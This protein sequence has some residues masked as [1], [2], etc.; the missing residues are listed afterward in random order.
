MI[1][2]R[3][4]AKLRAQDWTA[5]TIELVIVTLGVL[6]ALGLQQLV[7]TLSERTA[8]TRARG[9]IREELGL[10]L[11]LLQQRQQIQP[12][13]D[14]RLDEIGA[15]LDRLSQGEVENPP[16]WIG[17]PQ[18]WNMREYRWN[19]ASQSGHASLLSPEEQDTF[20]RI[21]DQLQRVEAV[22]NEEQRLWAQLRVLEG[23]QRLN[24]EAVYAMRSVLSQARF[25]NWNIKLIVT[26]AF[27]VAQGAGIKPIFLSRG[28][29]SVC[30]PLDTP[31][32]VALTMT[33]TPYGEP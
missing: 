12:C 9:D 22:Q 6:I 11:G 14:Q 13:I 25:T 1:F 27:D 26:Q 15:H 29:R 19:V 18:L 30:I 17:R 5:I 16:Q 4:V 7:N 8:A 33:E 3:A 24:S 10:N 20:T 28:S 31:R 23:E 32:A 21:H 2:R